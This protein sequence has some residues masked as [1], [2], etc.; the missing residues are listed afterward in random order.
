ME[1]FKAHM[2]K[3][4][5]LY[6]LLALAIGTFVGSQWSKWF[7]ALAMGRY[8][9]RATQL[10]DSLV[11]NLISRFQSTGRSTPDKIAR[12][13]TRLNSLDN[14]Q[15]NKLYNSPNTERQKSC[16]GEYWDCMSEPESK[17]STCWGY[18]LDC[19]ASIYY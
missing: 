15:L 4:G 16:A 5:I 19:D 7:P 2:G 8:S 11:N 10:K 17:P 6:I 12:L 3:F 14:N 9:R 18:Y 13:R 1:K